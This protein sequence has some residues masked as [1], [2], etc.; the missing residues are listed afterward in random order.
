M[1]EGLIGSKEVAYMLG[2]S[3]STFCDWRW[4]GKDVPPGYFLNGKYRYR[5]EEVQDWIATRP[6][7]RKA[8]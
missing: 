6:R 5:R 4:L 7:A 8:G 3:H 1:D 2:V